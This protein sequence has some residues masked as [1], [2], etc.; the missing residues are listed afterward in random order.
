[1]R[2]AAIGKWLV[3]AL[4]GV[5][6]V[7]VTIGLGS[8]LGP[9]GQ[10]SVTSPPSTYR[11][12][13]AAVPPQSVPQ[14]PAVTVPGGVP[15]S[16]AV[17]AGLALTRADS[18]G[19]PPDFQLSYSFSGMTVTEVAS[20]ITQVLTSK[21]WQVQEVGTAMDSV[22][23]NVSGFGWSGSVSVSDAVGPEVDVNLAQAA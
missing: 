13:P 17:P 6:V 1:M 11:G 18:V 9:D 20:A 21:G 15:G 22:V 19:T 10:V 16:F 23:E 7:L 14:E 2:Q 3:M 5:V 4:A 12:N 8:H